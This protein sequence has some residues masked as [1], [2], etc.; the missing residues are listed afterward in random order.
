MREEQRQNA[1]WMFLTYTFVLVMVLVMLVPLYWMVVAATLP[2]SEFLQFPPRL[3][4]GTAFFE[5]F[6]VLQGRIN[7]LQSVGNSVIIAVVYTVLSLLLCSMAGFAF[8][9][10][11][12]K[13]KEKIFYTILAT[14][15]LPI[16]LLVIPLFLLMAQMGWTNTFLAIILPWAANPIGIFLMRQNMKSIPD[17]LLESARMDG[18]SEFQ[19][20]YRI[21]LPTMRSSLA[22][23]AIILFL[24]Q[25]DLFLYPLVILE[26]PDM[27]TIP[28]ALAQLTGAQRIYYDQ[29]MVAASLAIL[30][31]ILLFLVLQKQFVSGI[32]AG[33]LKE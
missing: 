15:V 30:P 10:Y 16:Q 24:F 20:F 25:W 28:V 4:P 21:A 7:F 19:I 17:A 22:A 31:M 26:T 13:Y 32:L 9:K 1:V 3:F 12:F 2:Q 23:L 18:A 14:L 27:Y 8:A 29:I 6:G 5:N 33:S 11:E